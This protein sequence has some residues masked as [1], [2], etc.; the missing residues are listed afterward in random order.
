MAA[1][2]DSRRAAERVGRDGQ[3]WRAA[4]LTRAASGASWSPSIETLVALAAERDGRGGLSRSPPHT[5]GGG[6][7]GECVAAKGRVG[8]SSAGPLGLQHLQNWD[9]VGRNRGCGSRLR[10]S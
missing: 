9:R 5:G 10:V 1:E 3:L 4:S 7:S 8:C 2:G 6:E